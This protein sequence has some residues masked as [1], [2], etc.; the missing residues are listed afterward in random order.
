MGAGRHEFASPGWIDCVD[1][2]ISERLAAVDLTGITASSSEEFTDPP[3]HLLHGDAKTIGWHWRI[4]DGVLR[5]IDIPYSEAERRVIGDY[6]AIV[7]IARLPHADP[8]FDALA[9]SAID[10]GSLRIEG[11]HGEGGKVVRRA[12][13][14]LHDELIPFT[15]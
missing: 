15:A 2:L 10:N 13:A 7:T 12:L 4:D 9:Q 14:D 1:R 5:V 11:R 6:A 8:Q 3:A